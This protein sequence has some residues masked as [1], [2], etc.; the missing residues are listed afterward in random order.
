[1]IRANKTAIENTFLCNREIRYC[2]K[3]YEKPIWNIRKDKENPP[4]CRQPGRA[5]LRAG[6]LSEPEA[7]PEGGGRERVG[8]KG[9][10][11]IAKTLKKQS[12]FPS[13]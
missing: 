12:I 6:V 5:S 4:P 2:Q 13:P 11:G 7:G 9:L 1:V 3:F 10:N 8:V